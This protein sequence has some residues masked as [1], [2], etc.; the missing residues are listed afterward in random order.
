[1][2]PH[3]GDTKMRLRTILIGALTVMAGLANAQTRRAAIVGGGDASRGKCTLEVMVDGSAQ[4]E[5]RGDSATLRDTSG[6]T[7]Q[8][9]RF[10]CTGPMPANPGNFRFSGINGR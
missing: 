4:V 5:V 7:P 9:R 3:C 1:M 6:Q 2:L 8:W 10:E